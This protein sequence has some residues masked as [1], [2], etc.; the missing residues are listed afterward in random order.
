[1]VKDALKIRS[2]CVGLRAIRL[3][4]VVFACVAA[5]AAEQREATASELEA[6]SPGVTLPVQ[7]GRLLRAGKVKGR[8]SDRCKD[9]A[10]GSGE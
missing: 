8:N 9:D 5:T 3:L 10:K 6:L 7:L 2:L 1:M 4:V